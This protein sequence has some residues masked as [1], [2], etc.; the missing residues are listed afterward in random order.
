LNI[1]LEKPTDYDW[2]TIND[3]F[4]IRTILRTFGDDEKKKI[5]I[6]LLN[7]PEISSNVLKENNIPQTS[8][9][10][11]IKEMINDGMIIAKNIVILDGRRFYIYVP[12]FKDLKIQIVKDH[13]IV[14]V[15]MNK[16]TAV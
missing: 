6:S 5:L 8:G 4:H 1:N 9:Y 10:R 11:K 15:K 13:V 14:K 16:Q 2:V 12:V 3:K 7:D